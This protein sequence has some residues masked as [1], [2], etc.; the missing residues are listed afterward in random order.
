MQMCPFSLL[1]YSCAS[2]NLYM[3]LY[4]HLRSSLA[5]IFLV[6]AKIG[7]TEA[8]LGLITKTSLLTLQTD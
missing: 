1:L 6:T 7:L 8:G 3:L 5:R 2:L 4:F